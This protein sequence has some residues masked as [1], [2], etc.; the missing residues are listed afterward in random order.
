MVEQLE[1]PDDVPDAP[2]ADAFAAIMRFFRAAWMRKG[3][4]AASV[5]ICCALGGFHYSTAIRLYESSAQILV[6][7]TGSEVMRSGDGANTPRNVQSHLPTHVKI[8]ASDKVIGQAIADLPSD[9]RIDVRGVSAEKQIGAIRRR[10]RVST[11]KQTSL[12]GV[13]YQSVDP[14]AAVVVVE[15]IVASY[16]KFMNE[17][18]KDNS[19]ELLGILTREKVDL[20]RALLEKEA[21][22]MRLRSESEIVISGDS[23]I[24]EITLRY[25]DLATAHSDAQ[26]RTINAK[27]RLAAMRQAIQNGEGIQQYLTQSD[28]ALAHDILMKTMGLETRQEW[29][30]NEHQRQLLQDKSLLQEKQVIYGPKHPVITQLQDRI[31]TTQRWLS[32]RSYLIAK[33]ARTL[34]DQELQPRLV[35]MAVQQVAQSLEHERALRR[36]VDEIKPEAIS[37]NNQIAKIEI[38]GLDMERMRSMYDL[39]LER[40]KDIDLGLDNGLK[41]SVVG[42]PVVA[43]SP[44]SPKLRQIGLLSLFAGLGFGFA[45]VYVLDLL[46]DRFRSPEE[47]KMQLGTPVLSMVRQLEQLPGHGIEAVQTFAQPNSIGAE[48]FRTLRTVITFSDTKPRRILT[49]SSEPGDG[50]STVISNLSIAFAQAGQRTLLI[51]ADMRRPGITAMLDMT[52]RQGLSTILRDEQPMSESI[53]ECLHSS[54]LPPFN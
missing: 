52:R 22:L 44:V 13:T 37:L 15:A 5:L 12:I 35:E 19:R 20:E 51:D 18:H 40:M 26:S 30:V 17:T 9:Y 21:E 53:R 41:T 43:K 7:N 2:T 33:S 1:L 45:L 31:A 50:K 34:R 8:V 29:S 54:G 16:Q 47:I 38:L 27:S 4:I 23:Q 11:V 46:D 10:L 6:T 42:E 24:N 32:D 48:S 14:E 25:H 28:Q 49:T 36:Q 39:L 3:V